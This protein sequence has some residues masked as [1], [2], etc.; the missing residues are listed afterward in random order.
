MAFLMQAYLILHK[1]HS[2][3]TEITLAASLVDHTQLLPVHG[4][5][6]KL[7]SHLQTPPKRVE[8]VVLCVLL[9]C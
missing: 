5:P 1:L 8:A 9:V 3:A 4:L 6:G 2:V 7:G